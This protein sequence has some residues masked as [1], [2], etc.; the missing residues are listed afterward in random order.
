M[1]VS[2]GIGLCECCGLRFVVGGPTWLFVE[3]LV[4]E[5]DFRGVRI[6]GADDVSGDGVKLH[7]PRA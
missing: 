5:V 7:M 3:S 4:L 6:T 1:E 2:G